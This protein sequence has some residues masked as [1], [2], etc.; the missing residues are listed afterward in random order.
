MKIGVLTFHRSYNYGAYMQ[1]FSL[2]TK[3]KS[4]YPQHDIEVIDYTSFK[5]LKGYEN[6]INNAKTKKLARLL[7]ERNN[8]FIECQEKL[9]LSSKKFISDNM[10]DIVAYMNQEYDV[11]VVGSDAVFNWIARGFPNLY[12]LKDYNGK[13]LSYAASAHGMNYQNMTEQ[14]KQYLAQAF[15]DFSYIGV[16]DITTENMVKFV[17]DGLKPYHNCDPTMFLDLNQVPCDLEKLKLKLKNKG[18]D[19][20]KP[21]IGV[22]ANNSIGYEIKKK[23]KKR[24]QLIA[25]YEP[26]RYADVFLNDL[27]PFEW[28]HV[29]SF[30]KVTVTHFFHGTMLSLVNSVPVIPVE[31]INEFSAKNTTKI[32]DLMGRLGLSEWREE[33]DYRGFSF[34][35]R[36]LCRLKFITDKKLW[37]RVNKRIELFLENDYSSQIKEKVNVEKQYYNSFEE[38]L[39]SI[40]NK[41]EKND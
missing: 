10:T 35:K 7:Q 3:L 8:S 6:A 40:I 11:V 33:A 20:S 31:F 18:V 39:N 21:L 19:F 9:P 36:V 34:I 32:K 41:G 15:A 5:A 28:A 1:C 29:F 25:L 4:T 26:N 38:T 37:N 16:R 17:D 14:Q 13:K 12:F 30:F 2:I 23:F 22:M 27:T 24:V